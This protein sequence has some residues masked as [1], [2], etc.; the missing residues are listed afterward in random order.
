VASPQSIFAANQAQTLTG[1]GISG[2]IDEPRSF[3]KSCG[4]WVVLVSPTH[5]AGGVAGCAI[6]A[7]YSS[8]HGFSIVRRLKEF[9]FRVW[10]RS[11]VWFDHADFLEEW[12]EIYHQV[13]DD[14]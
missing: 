5:G 12:I 13:S 10:P 4:P 11:E 7:I 6:D 1:S 8:I 3:Q 2:V 14:R 9:L